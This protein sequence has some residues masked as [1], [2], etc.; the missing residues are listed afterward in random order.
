MCSMARR[1]LSRFLSLRI[2]KQQR[3]AAGEQDV[4]H[5]GVLLQVLDG[6]VEIEL[7]FLLA[8][9]ADDAAARAVAAVGG[10]AVRDQKED[11]VGIAM[12]QAGH[13]HV[14]IL[15]AR[16]GHVGRRVG[17]FLDARNHLAADRAIGIERIDQVEEVGRDAHGQLGVGQEHAGM[18]LAR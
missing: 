12:D 13:G 17:H 6:A 16:I 10:A 11:A 7:E 1:R 14:V 4:A 5:F 15:A 3:V 8:H 9:A 2:G 18:F